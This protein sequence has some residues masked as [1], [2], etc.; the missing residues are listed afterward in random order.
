MFF[1]NAF[2][3]TTHEKKSCE[4]FR[5]ISFTNKPDPWPTRWCT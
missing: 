2:Y 5:A 3:I 1:Q 4:Y